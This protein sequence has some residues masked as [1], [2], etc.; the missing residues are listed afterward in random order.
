MTT[1]TLQSPFPIP[2]I[3]ATVPS[4][5]PEKASKATYWITQR[6]RIYVCTLGLVVQSMQ[7]RFAYLRERE[8]TVYIYI[9]VCVCVCV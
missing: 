9:C 7:V 4:A 1:G 3:I 5:R 2:I 6:V 8:Y